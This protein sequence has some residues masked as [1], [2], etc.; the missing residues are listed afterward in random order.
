M[1]DLLRRY[2]GAGLKLFSFSLCSLDD[3]IFINRTEFLKK[4]P[5]FCVFSNGMPFALKYSIEEDLI[6]LEGTKS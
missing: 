1:S 5:H 3:R 2:A 4:K 6:D